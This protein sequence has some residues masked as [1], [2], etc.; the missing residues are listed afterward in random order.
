MSS[1]NIPRIVHF[2]FG[3]RPQTEPFHLLHYLALESCRRV[4]RPERIYFHCAALPYGSYWDLIRPA[5]TLMPVT[6]ARDVL[7]ADYSRGF[8]PEAYRYAHHADVIRLDALIE[9]GGIYADIDTI[10]LR[11]LPA[12]LYRHPF[13]IGEEG[14]VRDEI[15]GDWRPSL[16]NA[17]M[18]ARPS[19]PYAIAWRERLASALNGSWSNHSCLLAQRLSEECPQ[20]VHV[21]PQASF[22][23]VVCAPDDVRRLLE[24]NDLDLSASYTMHLWAHVW[25]DEWRHDFSTRHAGHFTAD[26]IRRVDTTLNRVLRAYL[27]HIEVW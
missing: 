25:W 15:T 22:F 12:D 7:E 21:E 4:L 9:H 11:P 26:D 10:F 27:P 1:V 23:P 6:P 17:F 24:R 13:V 18:M 5:L 8:V 3:L 16:C 19:A 2:V 20:D 14:M